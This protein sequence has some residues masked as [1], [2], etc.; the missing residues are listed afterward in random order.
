M[1]DLQ[2]GAQLSEILAD[3]READEE[4]DVE[5][6]RAALERVAQLIGQ[7]FEPE[8]APGLYYGAETTD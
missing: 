4:G 8:I 5:G 7:K 6:L 2:L 3:A 1:S